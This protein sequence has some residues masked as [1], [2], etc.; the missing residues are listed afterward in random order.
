MNYIFGKKKLKINQSMN[1]LSIVIPCYNEEKN[2]DPLFKKI[3]ELLYLDKTLEIII[4]EN[5]STDNTK[6]N[7][8]KSNLVNEGKIII[9]EVEENIGYGHGIMSGVNISNGEYIGWCH[10]DL[11]TEPR[12]V[13]NAYIHNLELLNNEK[14][15]IKGLRKNRNLF[16]SFFTFCM[17][18]IASVIF[19]RLI[20]DINAQP[21]IFS[22]KFKNY[23]NDYP[24]DFSL[25]LYFLIIAKIKNY[26]IIN[27]DVVLKK[28]LYNEA[29]GGGN[30]SGKIK[31]IKRTLLYMFKL[32]MKIWKL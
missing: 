9:H 1:K 11:Q 20:N 6:E 31:L 12:D 27:Y 25:D 13:Y 10:A 26:K 3:E 8:L 22:K 15:V 14:I 32:K 29:K 24:Y 30:I 21:K 5:G 18:A 7:I 28:R 17:S 23:L 2:I 16:D 19:L 4:V